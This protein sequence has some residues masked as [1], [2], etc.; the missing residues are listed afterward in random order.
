M[1]S[2]IDAGMPVGWHFSKSALRAAGRLGAKAV[3]E[4]VLPE[5]AIAWRGPEARGRGLG[6]GSRRTRVALTFDDG[7]TE[8]TRA[9]LSVLER[10]RARATFFVIGELCVAHP[11]LVSAIAD[12]G[13]E[14]AGHGYTHRRFPTLS[15]SALKDE[16]VRTAALLP[17]SAQ[18]RALV[19][20]P[21]GAVSLSSLVTCARASFTTALWS[22]D[23]GDWRTKR[24]ADVIEAFHDEGAS[25]PG[26][27]VLLHEGQTWTMEA[28]PAI[29]GGLTEAG[30]QLVTMSEML[31]APPSYQV[32]A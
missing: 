24:S 10:F 23:S 15:A 9:Y 2:P 18:G 16:L 20:P 25:T 3:A 12:G 7:P 30:H 17:R 31:G 32:T 5:S 29:L 13:H 6:L 26:A 4:A 8:L 28:L 1:P 19:R 14:L 22:F 27:V 11:E 21:H